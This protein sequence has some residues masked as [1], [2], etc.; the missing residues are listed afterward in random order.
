M[1]GNSDTWASPR[2]TAGFQDLG[3]NSTDRILR[4]MF[5]RFMQ[6]V[7]DQVNVDLKYHSPRS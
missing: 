5:D 2:A 3:P 4:H 7:V 6:N 1:F